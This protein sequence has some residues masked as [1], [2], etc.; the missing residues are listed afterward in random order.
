MKWTTCA[1]P[2]IDGCLEIDFQDGDFS[3]II[4]L[5]AMYN[6]SPC[7]F[8][9]HFVNDSSASVGVVTGG[10]P[11]ENGS[12]LEVLKKRVIPL[13]VFWLNDKNCTDLNFSHFFVNWV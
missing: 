11:F 9:G 12:A 1:D 7:I 13:L 2:S 6:D 4:C 3:D 10:C 5:K 8:K